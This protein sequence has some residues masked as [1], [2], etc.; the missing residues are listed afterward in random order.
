MPLRL[1]DS[2]TAYSLGELRVTP[3]HR[4]VLVAFPASLAAGP[5]RPGLPVAATPE[6]SRRSANS[7]Q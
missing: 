7:S 3:G 1:L 5:P 4:M 6:P 2:L